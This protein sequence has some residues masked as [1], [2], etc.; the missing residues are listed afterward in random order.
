METKGMTV[1]DM[2]S[3]W[4]IEGIRSMEGSLVIKPCRSEDNSIELLHKY[5]LIKIEQ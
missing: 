2:I 4:A 1:E 3:E 5:K